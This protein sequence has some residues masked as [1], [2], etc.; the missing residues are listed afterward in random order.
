MNDCRVIFV[1]VG[2]HG[3]IEDE[4]FVSTRCPEQ[5]P[6]RSPMQKSSGEILDL[7]AFPLDAHSIR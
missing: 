4:R 1:P 7:D 6:R 3:A 2:P 5:T